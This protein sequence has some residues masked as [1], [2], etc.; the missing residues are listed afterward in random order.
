MIDTTKSGSRADQNQKDGEVPESQTKT[1]T[2]EGNSQHIQSH[3]SKP[4]SGGLKLVNARRGEFYC[5]P[6]DGVIG[7]ALQIYGEWAENEIDFMRQFVLPGTTVIDAGANIGT[8]TAAFSQFVGPSGHVVAIEASPEVAAVLRQNVEINELKN[9]EVVC[10][11]LSKDAGEAF[12]PQI[13]PNTWLNVGGLSISKNKVSSKLRTRMDTLD[14]FKI[15]N[16]SL[17]K[18][19]VEGA[20]LDVLSSAKETIESN[21]AVL[22]CELN[23]LDLAVEIIRHLSAYDYRTYVASFAAFNANNYY[24]APNSFGHAREASLIFVPLN[25]Q[26][27]TATAGCDL[28]LFTSISD[29]ASFFM[30]MPRYGDITDHDRIP[31]KTSKELALCRYQLDVARELLKISER[32]LTL[33]TDH[34]TSMENK[35][36]SML[37]LSPGGIE[38]S[39]TQ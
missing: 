29:L 23:D 31:E 15:K 39:D 28:R 33:A 32:K 4:D 19:D 26:I 3:A 8:L 22:I 30:E 13:P 18:L 35:M 37:A 10:C 34:I 21:S 25:K 11:A 38:K 36:I 7:Q 14:S 12:I 16:V 27:P 17:I 24:H 5:F 2:E 9:V 20:E 1:F 6:F